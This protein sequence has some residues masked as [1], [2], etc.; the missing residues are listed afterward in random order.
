MVFLCH[1]L[2][3]YV[4]AKQQNTLL[5]QPIQKVQTVQTSVLH[6]ILKFWKTI[7]LVSPSCLKAW[8]HLK[9]KPLALAVLK[10]DLPDEK[11]S[12]SVGQ[13]KP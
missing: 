8:G 7:T 3:V 13:R 11:G 9:N 5:F 4:C 1:I 12:Q 10:E 2:S 6:N